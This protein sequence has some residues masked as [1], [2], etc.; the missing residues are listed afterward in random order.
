MQRFAFRA[1]RFAL[2]DG[3]PNEEGRLP[4]EPPS[5][6]MSSRPQA[7]G[8]PAFL[9]RRENTAAAPAP[10]SSTIDGSGTWVPEVEP[11][12]L[13]VEPVE[14]VLLDVLDEELVELEVEELV[15]VDVDEL[16]ELDEEEL[17]DVLEVMLPD[18]VVVVD[19]LPEVV[20]LETLPD[21]VVV[22]DTL[23]EVVVVV[24]V[25]PEELPD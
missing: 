8:I 11:V 7:A 21:V 10:N 23:P 13:E 20:V 12:V 16:V 22:V 14:P 9:R 4:P 3:A 17:L 15:E 19:T 1:V 18:V 25:L 2:N 6:A 5:C 24:V